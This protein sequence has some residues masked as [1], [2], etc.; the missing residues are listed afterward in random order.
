MGKVTFH[1]LAKLGKVGRL[2]GSFVS[3][4]NLRRR[5]PDPKKKDEKDRPEKSNGAV[6]LKPED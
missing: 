3:G 1:G 5:T 6:G 2:G 4:R